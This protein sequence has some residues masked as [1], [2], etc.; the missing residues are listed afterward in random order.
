VKRRSLSTGTCDARCNFQVLSYLTLIAS[1]WNNH[2]LFNLH[3]QR[4]RM[5]TRPSGGYSCISGERRT[6]HSSDHMFDKMRTSERGSCVDKVHAACRGTNAKSTPRFSRAYG[7]DGP[8][9]KDFGVATSVQTGH[10]WTKLI[11]S[12]PRRYLA[13]LNAILPIVMLR[14]GRRWFGAL[15]AESW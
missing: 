13:N 4:Q 6:S 8:N 11:S 10:R 12:R 14:S 3:D 1:F 15:L 7:K 9:S 2:L 5:E